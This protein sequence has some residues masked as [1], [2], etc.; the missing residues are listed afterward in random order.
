MGVFFSSRRRHTRCAISS[1]RSSAFAAHEPSRRDRVAPSPSWR[2][3]MPVHSHGRPAR[4]QP[5]G[6]PT[7]LTTTLKLHHFRA[8]SSRPERVRSMLHLRLKGQAAAK[9][10]KN[11]HLP[12]TT[13]G[14]LIIDEIIDSASATYQCRVPFRGHTASG[15]RLAWTI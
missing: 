7:V 15:G 10:G 4:P 5:K 9:P 13:G 6:Y 14:A 3:S 12:A 8:V 1:G 2:F 11:S